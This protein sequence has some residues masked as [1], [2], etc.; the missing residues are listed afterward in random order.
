MN[1]LPYRNWLT[2]KQVADYFS[3]SEKTIE[4]WDATG[5]LHS[6]KEGRVRRYHPD[7]LEPGYILRSSFAV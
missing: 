1:G 4:R 3:V 2:K 6:L 5:R 7:Y